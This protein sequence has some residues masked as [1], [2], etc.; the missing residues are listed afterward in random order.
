MHGSLPPLASLRWSLALALATALVAAGAG[1]QGVPVGKGK[2]GPKRKAPAAAAILELDDEPAPRKLP[3]K[4]NVK[5]PASPLSPLSSASSTARPAKGAPPP[6]PA[7]PP[8][9][10]AASSVDEASDTEVFGSDDLAPALAPAPPAI[11]VDEERFE[12]SGWTRFRASLMGQDDGRAPADPLFS[13]VVPDASQTVLPYDRVTGDLQ[14]YLRA[15]Y[16]KG[17]RFEAV[18]AASA[19]WSAFGNAEPTASAFAGLSSSQPRTSFEAVVREGWLGIYRDALDLRI[20]LQR[21]SWGK[22]DAFT[23]NDV[24]N[25]RDVRDPFLTETALQ[26]LPTLALRADLP[27]GARASLQLH[28]SPF[29]T[30]DAFDLWGS[31]GALIQPSAPASLRYLLNRVGRLVDPTLRAEILGIIGQTQKPRLDFTEASGGARLGWEAGG[32]DGALY[33]HYGFHTQPYLRVSPDLPAAFAS[34]DL[35]T[36]GGLAKPFLDATE[37]GAPLVLS[38]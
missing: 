20:G 23:P 18:V 4:K 13:T 36:A 22:S 15:R 14:G 31:N 29:F 27:L 24:V 11:P 3:P 25:A 19:S 28:A 8:P 6:A 34:A 38:T 9:P 12:L 37:R 5:P 7:P 1:A 35:S 33:A 2:G 16:R 21:I 26:R 32:F 10:H 30:P 17:K